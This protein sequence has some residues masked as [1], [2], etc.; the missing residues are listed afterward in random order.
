MASVEQ[1][2]QQILQY[3]DVCDRCEIAI[4]TVY[5]EGIQISEKIQQYEKILNEPSTQQES[6]EYLIE[7]KNRL[8]GLIDKIRQA[9]YII[10]EISQKLPSNFQNMNKDDLFESEKMNILRGTVK[11]L[12]QMYSRRE[13]K[14]ESILIL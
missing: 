11:G 9:S 7:E 6:P 5:N 4:N 12:R 3:K 1:I 13:K 2:Y 10:E 8:Y 14:N